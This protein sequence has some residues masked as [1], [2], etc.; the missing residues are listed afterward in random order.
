MFELLINTIIPF[1]FI[2]TVL[3]FV[4]ELGHYIAAIQNGVKVEVFSVGFGKEL[5]DTQTNQVQD[6]NSL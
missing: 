2:L 1:L 6:G 5:L 3:V 4:H